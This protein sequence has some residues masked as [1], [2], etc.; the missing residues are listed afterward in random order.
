M[1]LADIERVCHTHRYWKHNILVSFY[2]ISAMY[3]SAEV[4]KQLTILSIANT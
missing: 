3:K 2:N 1:Y 4:R